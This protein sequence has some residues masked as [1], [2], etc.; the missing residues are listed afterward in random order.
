M[1]KSLLSPTALLGALAVAVGYATP[2]LAGVEVVTVPEPMTL[3][4][5]AA[6]AGGLYV[7]RRFRR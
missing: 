4:A 1:I 6:G 5:L 7:L 2:A 3:A